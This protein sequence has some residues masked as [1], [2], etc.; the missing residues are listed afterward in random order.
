MLNA[1]MMGGV[2]FQKGLGVTH[3]LAHALSTVCDLHHGLAN[4]IMIPYAMGFNRDTVSQ[5]LADLAVAVGANPATADGFLQWLVDLRKKLDIPA[6]LAS[7]GVKGEHLD[8]LI[9]IA[10]ADGCHANNPRTVVAGDFRAMFTQA[11]G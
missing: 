4:G 8:R 9:E 11:L 3:S 6:T 1:A 5:R 2:A 10:V 7:S